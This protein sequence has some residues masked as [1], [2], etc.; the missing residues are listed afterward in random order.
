MLLGSDDTDGV[1]LGCPVGVL[2]G[3]DDTDGVTLGSLLGDADGCDVEG[4]GEGEG[5]LGVADGADVGFAIHLLGPYTKAA[6]PYVKGEAGTDA[7]LHV[8]FRLEA[9]FHSTEKLANVD[10]SSDLYSFSISLMSAE[11]RPNRNETQCEILHAV[12]GCAVGMVLGSDDGRVD[13]MLLGDAL[14]DALGMLGHF[15]SLV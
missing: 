6:C 1:T 8:L 7:I 13:G 3:S 9:T 4:E 11:V 14:G 12:G 5:A 10:S 15:G 2:L